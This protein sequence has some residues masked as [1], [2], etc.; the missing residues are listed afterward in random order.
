MAPR[1]DHGGSDTTTKTFRQ[2]THASE[3]RMAIERLDLVPSLYTYTVRTSMMPIRSVQSELITLYFS[4]I[5]PMFPVVD[6]HHFFALHQ[7][8]RGR[9]EFMDPADFLIYNAIMAASFSV[10]FLT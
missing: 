6:E 1:Q 9:E 3:S 2:E 8:F 7:E 10:F 4:H 5:H